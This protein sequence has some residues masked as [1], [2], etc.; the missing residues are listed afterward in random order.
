MINVPIRITQTTE[1]LI[2]IVLTNNPS[3][4]SK[5]ITKPLSLSDHELFGYTN[6]KHNI[7]AITEVTILNYS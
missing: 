7:D 5:V 6:I 1:V 4:I 2:D 3:T